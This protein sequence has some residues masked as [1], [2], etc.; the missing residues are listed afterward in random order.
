MP[1][2]VRQLNYVTVAGLIL[3][4]GGLIGIALGAFLY[5]KADAGL[6]S[7]DA[8]YA[9]QGQMMTY[10]ADG[11]F[12]D[13][14]TAAGGDAILGL[15]EDDWK[16]PLN[17]ANLDPNDPLV[18]TPDELM[19]KY[20]T[21]T[22]HT[23]HG[24]QTVVLTEDVEYKGT[25]YKAGT[26]D[27]PVDGRYFGDLDRSHPLEGK[28]REQAWS[29]LAYGLLGQLIGGVNSDYQAGLAHFM[30]WSIFVGLGFMFTM[31]GIFVTIGGWQ[32]T[33]KAMVESEARVRAGRQ[34]TAVGFA[35]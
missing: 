12:T 30:S 17:R 28:V 19:V 20:A 32:L 29:P 7:L 14:G 15:L 25:L 22:Y 6:K 16:F 31:A 24:T 5:F 18:N 2:A 33:K 13:R 9:A 26:Y 10:D 11:N 27:V 35:D 23:L 21:I 8:V 4:V 3:V 1:Q 34:V